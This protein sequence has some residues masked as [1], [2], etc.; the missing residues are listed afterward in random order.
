MTSGIV[1]GCY[2]VVSLIT[3]RLLY[4]RWRGE[5]KALGGFELYCRKCR[6]YAASLASDH[7]TVLR[8]IIAALF[9]PLALL[10]FAVV[11]RPPPTAA[12]RAAT[13][14]RLKARIAELEREAGLS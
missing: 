7:E 8:V 10:V 3:A 4:A 9:W 6:A 12:E 1:L 2:A 5:M 11:F 13:E 14:A